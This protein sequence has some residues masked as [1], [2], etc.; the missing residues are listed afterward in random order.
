MCFVNAAVWRN[1]FTHWLLGHLSGDKLWA[2]DELRE[3]GV[4][5]VGQGQAR[6]GPL[7]R[8]HL[9]PD[10]HVYHLHLLTV[11]QSLRE[12]PQL[13]QGSIAYTLAVHFQM[14]RSEPT[15]HSC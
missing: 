2:V 1:R 8:V 11:L 9:P 12:E 14:F 13:T 10:L 7:L 5:L 6:Q 15:N 3:V 4:G